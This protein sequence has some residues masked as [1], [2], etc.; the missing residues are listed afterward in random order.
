MLLE[1]FSAIILGTIAGVFAGLLPG[2]HPNLIAVLL[3]ASSP[4]LLNYLDPIPLALFIISMAVNNLFLSAIPATFLGAPEE[5]TALSILPNHKLLLK[6]RGFEAVVLSTIGALCSLILVLTLTPII[7]LIAKPGYDFISNKIGYILLA[8]CTILIL[9]ERKSKLFAL[10]LFL[11]SGA[12]GLAVL[13]SPIKEPLFPLFSGLFG[14]SSLLLS[15]RIT[16]NLPQQQITFPEIRTLSGF[17]AIFISIIA[18]CLASFLPGLG[19]SQ[20]AAL[21]SSFTRKLKGKYFLMIIGGLNAVNIVVS[22]IALYTIEKSRSGAVVAIS[23][24]IQDISLNELTLFLSATLLVAGISTIITLQ[25]SKVFISLIEKINYNLLCLLTTIFITLLVIILTG[26]LGLLVLITSTALGIL[27]QLN[28]TGR[29]HLMGCLLVPVI[30][31]F[32]L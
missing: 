14:T 2:I 4:T 6:G 18:G 7:L 25:L 1:I 22:F 20:V 23:K 17:T 24:L 13:N 30:L 21:S 28:G 9:R 32:L 15:L 26:P 16:N 29:N 27:P 19:P 12:L 8:A 5:E 11:L 3:I 10:I 31:F